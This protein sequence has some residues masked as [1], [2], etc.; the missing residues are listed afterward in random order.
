MQILADENIPGLESFA[1]LGEVV[2]MPGRSISRADLSR[3]ELLLVRSVTRVDADLLAGTP[4]RFVGTATIGTDHLDTHWLARQGIPWCAAPGSNAEAVVD[5][6]LG[7]FAALELFPALFAGARVG[8]VGMGNVGSR[9]YRRLHALGIACRAYD[10]LLPATA[11]PVLGDLSAVLACE[12]VC[13]HA[14]LTTSGPFPSWHLLGRAQLSAMPDG[15]LLINAG[16]GPVVAN[17]DLVSG[18]SSPRLVL[19]VWEEEPAVDPVLVQHCELATPHIAGYSSAGKWR[20]TAMLREAVVSLA[21]CPAGPGFSLPE[22]SVYC[23][24]RGHRASDLAAAILQVY[25]PVEDDRRFRARCG[26]YC[27]PQGFDALRKDYPQRWEIG[28]TRISNAT[29]LSDRLLSDLRA[30]GFAG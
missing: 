14:P 30:A 29:E 12:V 15:A 18:G 20:A 7:V 10:P 11:F 16:R 21:G 19:D 27:N 13:V 24:E 8:I 26:Q 23:E 5:Y 2:R 9:L 6:V 4:V 3:T 22:Q 1:D 17:A 25:D 28:Q